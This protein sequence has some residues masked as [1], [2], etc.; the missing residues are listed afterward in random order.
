LAAATPESPTSPAA[1]TQGAGYH[2]IG[3]VW[4]YIA[5]P[6]TCTTNYTFATAQ[7]YYVS[8]STYF[9]ADVAFQPGCCIK[10]NGNYLLIYGSITCNG[11]SAN[12]SI[13]TAWNDDLL[14]GWIQTESSCPGYS[15]AQALWDYYITSSVS[16]S[17]MRFRWANTAIQFD[18]NSCYTHSVSGCSFEFCQVGIRK[19]GCD[20]AI[21]SSTRCGVS[22]QT[23][24]EGCGNSTGTLANICSGDSDGNGFPDLAEYQYFGRL[25]TLPGSVVGGVNTQTYGHSPSTD[26]V[27]WSTFDDTD[28]VYQYNPNCWLY[29]VT[30]LSSF[31]PWHS[32]GFSYSYQGGG[33]LITPRHAITITHMAFPDGTKV[34][35]VGTDNV[36][37]Q[38][39][40]L[41]TNTLADVDYCVMVFDQDLP[42]NVARA[43]VLPSNL[44][45]KLTPTMEEFGDPFGACYFSA[46]VPVVA[47]NQRKEAYI[48]DA[49]QFYSLWGWAFTHHSQ[50]FPDWGS[51]CY[52]NGGCSTCPGNDQIGGDSGSPTFLLINGELVLIGPWLG[53]G[54]ATW[55]GRYTSELNAAITDL[56]TWVSNTYGTNAMT[57]Y[58]A[59]T[60]PL[61][62]F[63][64]LW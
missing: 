25:G 7:T 59:T 6:A 27:I 47:F 15:A 5:V 16:V 12:P 19:S 29:G 45:Y 34:R 1:I 40:C 20:V 56:D 18:A 30:G 52:R 60:Y 11:S 38:V 55:P 31:S 43:R 21:S 57:G 23:S 2:P 35:F 41:H 10:F 51:Y 4:D 49:Y 9:S 14:G 58:T 17:G 36:A 33:T 50:W 54:T 3:L 63:P 37:H 8:S 46:N 62:S 42:A 13:L 53:C 39:T 32:G 44:I 24:G 28:M 26:Q 61:D 48:T 22:T 64:D